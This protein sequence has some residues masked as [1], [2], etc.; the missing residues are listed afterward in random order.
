[1]GPAQAYANVG[2][3]LAYTGRD[4]EA[5]DALTKAVKLDPRLTQPR[6]MLAQLDQRSPAAADV[7]RASLT[8]ITPPPPEED[9]LV[10]ELPVP[11]P[12]AAPKAR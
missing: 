5:R 11:V 6:V 1:M 4:E 10:L 2:M 7:S 12:H 9:A 8:H 3:L